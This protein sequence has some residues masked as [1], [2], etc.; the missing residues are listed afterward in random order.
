MGSLGAVLKNPDDLFPLLKLKRAMK[1]AEKQIPPKPHLGFCYSMLHKVSRSFALV[2][3][4]LDT[5][6]H[7]AVRPGNFLSFLCLLWWVCFVF[8]IDFWFGILRNG[9][10]FGFWEM[11]LDEEGRT[12]LGFWGLEEGSGTVDGERKKKNEK[13][14]NDENRVLKSRFPRGFLVHLSIASTRK[15]SLLNSICYTNSSLK[16]SRCKFS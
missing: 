15:S 9:F 5:N 13:E 7:N 3:Q 12:V 14:E 4:Q 11:D 10:G 16:D 8:F 6:L 2:I 1:H